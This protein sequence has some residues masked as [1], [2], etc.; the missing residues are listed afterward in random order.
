MQNKNLERITFIQISTEWL[1]FKKPR[2]KESTY[3]NY[4]FVIE[5]RLKEQF[6]NAN[7]K[8]FIEYDLNQYIENLRK[9]LAHKTVRDIISVLKAILRYAERKYD[10]DFK[11]DLVSLPTVYKS[12]VE[13]FPERARR[14][15]ERHCLRS[16]SIKDLGI[17][18]SLYTGLRIGEI[19]ALRWEDINF[20]DKVISVSHTLQ[21]VYQPQNYNS[22][23]ILTT[24]KTQSSI[25]KIPLAKLLYDKLKPIAKK[26]PKKAF[27][28]TGKE[29]KWVEPMGYRYTYKITLE[30]CKIPYK[31]Y[32]CLRHTFATRCV[33]IGM[34]V[35]SL[36]EILGHSNVS[37]TLNIYV[38]SCYEIKKK[39]IDKL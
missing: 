38:H 4:R 31:N 39:Y 11:L 2:V 30:Q 25:R 7:L 20:E 26:Y 21:R 34:D 35:K 33:R 36:S 9:G 15:L 8:F 22:K 6:G 24:P 37:V 16:D 29:E 23:I 28:L 19:C 1:L 18:I 10:M 27:I 17:L 32:H 3:L 13:V 5:K 12:Q 14:K